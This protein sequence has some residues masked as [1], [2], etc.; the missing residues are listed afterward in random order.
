M[1]YGSSAWLATY[2]LVMVNEWNL[3]ITFPIK[4]NFIYLFTVVAFTL[5]LELTGE[6]M[7]TYFFLLDFCMRKPH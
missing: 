7:A 2:V 1:I 4:Y 5:T 6:S 3:G